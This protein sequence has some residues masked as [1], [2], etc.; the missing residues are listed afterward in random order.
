MNNKGKA[1]LGK[2]ENILKVENYASLVITNQ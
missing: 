1:T 2:F